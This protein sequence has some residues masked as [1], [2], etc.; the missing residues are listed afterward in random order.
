[1]RWIKTERDRKKKRLF[2]GNEGLLIFKT[3]SE[4]DTVERYEVIVVT[5]WHHLQGRDDGFTN[6]RSYFGEVTLF[7]FEIL[8]GSGF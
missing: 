8:V 6:A 1:M 5:N 7:I 4:E 2:I 3:H